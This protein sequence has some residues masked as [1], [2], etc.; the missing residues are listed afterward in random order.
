MLSVWL[1]MIQGSI[2]QE[3]LSSGIDEGS[4]VSIRFVGWSDSSI[5]K[6]MDLFNLGLLDE[7]FADLGIVGSP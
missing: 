7:H 4:E 1:V 6:A 2:E 3:E 5:Q